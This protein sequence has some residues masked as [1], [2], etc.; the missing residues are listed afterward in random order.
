VR[1]RSIVSVLG[2]VS[3]R[4]FSGC[5]VR[6][7]WRCAS[8]GCSRA[9][10]VSSYG[11][12]PVRRMP[13]LDPT[14]VVH[15]CG[16]GPPTSS[17]CVGRSGRRC[18]PPGTGEPPNRRPSTGTGRL[19]ARTLKD[20]ARTMDAASPGASG[21]TWAR[22]TGGRSAGATRRPA[23]ARS[24]SAVVRGGERAAPGRRVFADLPASRDGQAD[25]ARVSV[26]TAGERWC[27]GSWVG[28]RSLGRG[29]V[30]AVIGDEI[31]R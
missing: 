28:G 17:C 2:A 9:L 29:G 25:R 31:C 21:T 19:E 24:G 12:A 14:D 16:G 13:L 27:G 30:T 26:K 11:P 20:G 6:G 4:S 8:C 1:A 5:A 15:L 23:T 3:R 22:P 10:V 7:G 18:R